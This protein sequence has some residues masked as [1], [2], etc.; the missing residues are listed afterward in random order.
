MV[1]LVIV[2]HKYW[3]KRTR[4][5]HASYEPL[6]NGDEFGMSAESLNPITYRRNTH[7]FALHKEELYDAESFLSQ[8]SKKR[9]Y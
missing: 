9:K 6:C 5:S 4:R 2:V 8:P 3:N 1:S 7:S